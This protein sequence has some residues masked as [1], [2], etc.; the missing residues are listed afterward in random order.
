MR[1]RLQAI[2]RPRST[3]TQLTQ[4]NL[5]LDGVRAVA[6]YLIVLHHIMFA[7]G[8]TSNSSYR[9]WGRFTGRFDVG[10]P[11]F[12]ILS[13][14]LLFKPFARAILSDQPLP[15][16]SQFWRKRLVRILPA[17][18]LA[19][20]VM[21]LIGAVQVGGASGFFFSAFLLNI[22]S[23]TH[24]ISGITQSWS[25]ATELSF[26]LIVPGLA[27]GLL[28]LTKHKPLRHRGVIALCFAASLYLSSIIFRVAVYFI[29]PSFSKVIPFW[30][31]SLVDI[32]ALGIALA[33][34]AELSHTQR[35]A[36]RVCNFVSRWATASVIVALAL[37]WIVSTQ[38]SLAVGLDTS[39]F[40]RETLRQGFYGLIGLFLVAPFALPG[41]QTKSHQFF[42]QRWLAWS[43]I[44]SY[45]VYLWHQVFISGN[46]A[47]RWM[48]YEFFDSQILSRVLITTCAT[49]VIAALSYYLFEE[50]L[51]RIAN[52]R[53][54]N[55]R[56]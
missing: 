20:I 27:H 7:A 26:Y 22:Y 16:S 24:L 12:F 54:R 41:P 3:N 9:F 10:V 51:S 23:T 21:L 39:G 42:G 2:V 45:G 28:L 8:I 37:F 52:K 5:A 31:P 17:Y 15:S 33:I 11:I 56:Q 40:V 49:F 6:A 29:E 34:L 43:G 4:H 48:P 19:L 53:V 25:L 38:F 50:P 44:V 55:S 36:Q 47:R 32:F 30:L 35:W 18:W 13:G 46:W 1:N 14:Y